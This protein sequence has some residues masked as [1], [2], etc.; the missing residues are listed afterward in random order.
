[1]SGFGVIVKVDTY[2]PIR[3]GRCRGLFS[4]VCQNENAF[5]DKAEQNASELKKSKL[6]SLVPGPLHRAQTRK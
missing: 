6:R 5:R 2:G 1:M 3:A 4:V